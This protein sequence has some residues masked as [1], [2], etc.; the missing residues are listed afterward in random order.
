MASEN[1][2]TPGPAAPPA[3]PPPTV[4]EYR[5]EQM[6][7]REMIEKQKQLSARLVRPLLPLLHLP[8]RHSPHSLH[9]S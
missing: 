2:K 4:Q 1:K 8:R 5:K 7:L 3:G 9:N 6:R